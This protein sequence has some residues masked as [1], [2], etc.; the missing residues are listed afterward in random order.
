M[1]SLPPLVYPSTHQ[2]F[3]LLEA[4]EAP[5]AGKGKR[6]ESITDGAL[7]ETLGYLLQAVDAVSEPLLWRSLEDKIMGYFSKSSPVNATKV[8]TSACCWLVCLFVCLL[9][10]YLLACFLVFFSCLLACLLAC[11]HFPHLT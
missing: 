3:L 8:R 5:Q 11:W 9:R 1:L 7:G 4:H 10:T 2:V 6:R